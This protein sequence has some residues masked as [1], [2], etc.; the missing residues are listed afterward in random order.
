MIEGD[1][2]QF[3]AIVENFLPENDL[4]T[5][6]TQLYPAQIVSLRNLKNKDV[7]SFFRLRPEKYHLNWSETYIQG[8]ADLTGGYPLNIVE[9][10]KNNKLPGLSP[11]SV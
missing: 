3:I 9:M 10:L 5:L 11:I 8:L 1:R 4:S 6:K 2:F 7:I